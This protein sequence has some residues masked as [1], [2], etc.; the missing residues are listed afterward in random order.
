MI[1][2]EVVSWTLGQ[3]VPDVCTF[4]LYRYAR[5]RAVAEQAAGR[6]VEIDRVSTELDLPIRSKLL[7]LEPKPRQLLK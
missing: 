7:R 4:A 1:S 3:R 6:Y 5:A 2:Y